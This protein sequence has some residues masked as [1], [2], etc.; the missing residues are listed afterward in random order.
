MTRLGELLLMHFMPARTFNDLI[1]LKST[2]KVSA[3]I[4]SVIGDET[5]FRCRRTCVV[6]I[7]QKITRAI[8]TDEPPK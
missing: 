5:T 2:A 7:T 1:L 6:E 4:G 3:A 8:G